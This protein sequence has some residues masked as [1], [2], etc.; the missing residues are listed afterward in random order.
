[1][2]VDEL[3]SSYVSIRSLTM[4]KPFIDICMHALLGTGTSNSVGRYRENLMLQLQHQ[5]C[6]LIFQRLNSLED[7]G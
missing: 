5:K 1:M 3:I 4:P 2:L 7:I 6:P